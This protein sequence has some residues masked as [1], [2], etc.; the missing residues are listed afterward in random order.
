MMTSIFLSNYV[1]SQC[2]LKVVNEPG[3][4]AI[5]RNT[6]EGVY[7]NNDL[8]NGLKSACMSIC[9]KISYDTTLT[10]YI[11]ITVISSGVYKDFI[12]R[13]VQIT[14]KDYSSLNLQANSYEDEYY[15]KNSIM[16]SVFKLDKKDLAEIN[17]KPIRKIDILD[18]RKGDKIEASINYSNLLIEQIN[19]LLNY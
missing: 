15:G 14:F 6:P 9:G 13:Q 1:F 5:I 19:C 8:E 3:C 16:I 10:P 11:Q 4:I 2:N 7:K 12:A 17:V 18:T